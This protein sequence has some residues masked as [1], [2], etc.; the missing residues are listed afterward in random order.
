[1]T[2]IKYS[3]SP[4]CTAR[5]IPNDALY[6]YNIPETDGVGGWVGGNTSPS[7]PGRVGTNTNTRASSKPP[8]FPSNKRT[9]LSSSDQAPQPS[10]TN[11]YAKP[12]W[13]NYGGA[14]GAAGGASSSGSIGGARGVL[15]SSSS[16]RGTS[17]SNESIVTE[18]TA[19]TNENDEVDEDAL[20]TFGDIAAA[21]ALGAK[22]GAG[23]RTWGS[24]LPMQGVSLRGSDGEEH[25]RSQ[26]QLQSEEQELDDELRKEFER[27]QDHDEDP[28]DE[29]TQHEKD[30]RPAVPGYPANVLQDKSTGPNRGKIVERA[31]YEGGGGLLPPA[32]LQSI[33][34]GDQ[35]LD[36]EG[37]KRQTGDDGAWGTP[38]RKP[39][40]RGGKGS[41]SGSAKKAKAV[42]FI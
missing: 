24:S 29:G 16:I 9:Y 40:T 6:T 10:P 36:A 15:N 31:G 37:L 33:V 25:E 34:Q 41:R 17:P 42:R 1:M 8:A 18:G 11:P 26:D 32:S 7:I 5:F 2:S 12:K 39:S 14:R 28:E 35:V 22:L 30:S 38:K 20:E 21:R 3:L 4:D 23:G 27:E 13:K 19:A